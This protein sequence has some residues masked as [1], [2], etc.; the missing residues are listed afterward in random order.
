[1]L[2]VAVEAGDTPSIRGIVRCLK[3]NW[4][5][6]FISYNKKTR[7]AVGV[8]RSSTCMKCGRRNRWT[9]QPLDKT[10]GN[11]VKYKCVSFMKRNSRT[12]RS[13][14]VEEAQLKNWALEHTKAM[15][16]RSQNYKN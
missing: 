14:L 4:Y 13:V 10:H 12:P 6:S 3:C 2:D 8:M 7:V 1:V 5:Q 11:H 15:F 9:I 16:V